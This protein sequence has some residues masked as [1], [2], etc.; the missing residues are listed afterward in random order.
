VI[1]RDNRIIKINLKKKGKHAEVV[2]YKVRV[3]AQLRNERKIDKSLYL[4]AMFRRWTVATIESLTVI[5]H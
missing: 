4:M 2:D 5:C 1:D 3:F